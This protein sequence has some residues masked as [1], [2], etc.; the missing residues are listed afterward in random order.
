MPHEEATAETG[1]VAPATG[2]GVAAAVLHVGASM[3]ERANACAA[4][5]AAC[6]AVDCSQAHAKKAKKAV[7]DA[8]KL[9]YILKADDK[10][11]SATDLR[12][13]LAGEALMGALPGDL[14]DASAQF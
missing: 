4:T 8:N 11:A 7:L 12:S 13:A 14:L 2:A 6:R 1:G 3:A 5:L 9:G 10:R